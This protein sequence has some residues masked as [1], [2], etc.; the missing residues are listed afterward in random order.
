MNFR[1]RWEIVCIFHRLGEG[2]DCTKLDQINANHT[3]NCYQLAWKKS[4]QQTVHGLEC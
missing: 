4:D 2:C 1:N 3:G